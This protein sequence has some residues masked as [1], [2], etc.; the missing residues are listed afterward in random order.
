MQHSPKKINKIQR[1]KIVMKL[2]MRL[3]LVSMLA[4]FMV[5]LAGSAWA[6]VVDEIQAYGLD[7]VRVADTVTVTGTVNKQAD[8]VLDLGDITGLVIDWKAN[9]TVTG[10]RKT[11]NRIGM[12]N[13]S[14]NGN[15]NLTGG[16]IDI[17][18][19]ESWVDAIYSPGGAPTVT[20]AGGTITSDRTKTT[21]INIGENA[22][23]TLVVTSGSLNI[24]KGNA[25]FADTLIVNNPA[26]INGL[27]CEGYHVDPIAYIYGNVTTVPD[28]EMFA[29]KYTPGTIS[30]SFTYIAESNAVWNIEGVTSDMADL[31]GIDIITMK[32][33]SGGTINFKNTNLTFKGTFNV[34][35]NGTL[36]VGVAQGDTSRL[37]H[38]GGTA[39]NDGTINIYGTLTNKDKL[40]NNG[41]MNNYSGQTLDNQGTLTNSGVINNKSTGKTINTGKLDNANGTINIE[42]GGTFQ[43][44]QTASEMGGT[45][46][47][48]AQSINNNTGGGGGGG[49]GC[50]TGFGLVGLLFAGFVALKR[51]G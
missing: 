11:Q 9:L 44:V 24:P 33:E 34:A 20:I 17:A 47:G 7:A 30:G 1:R 2:S 21:G 49:G 28:S 14:G 13:F 43:S 27:V 18:S 8:E 22:Q 16:T 26:I 42:D 38:V 15:F 46:N 5:M 6:D 39:T 37:T 40:I 35:Q 19:P 50:N 12:I 25:A 31:Q 45:V 23:G 36:N 4:V 48:T 32:V 29:E 10:G 3:K 51:L 41:T